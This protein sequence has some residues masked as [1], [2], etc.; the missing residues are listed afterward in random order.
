MMNDEGNRKDW[1]KIH[2]KRLLDKGKI[3][4]LV[5]SLRSIHSTN[6]EVIEKLRLEADYFEKMPSACVTQNSGASTSSPAPA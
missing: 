5:L 4:Q 1:I 3:E 6:P 2:R